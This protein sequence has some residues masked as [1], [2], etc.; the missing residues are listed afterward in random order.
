MSL[1]PGQQT[2]EKM[3][4]GM[5]MGELVFILTNIVIITSWSTRLAETGKSGEARC[6]GY[7]RGGLDVP[8]PGHHHPQVVL[9]H[10][11]TSFQMFWPKSL[12]D[13]SA[14]RSTGSFPTSFLS[15]IEADGVG[16]FH[17]QQK[18]HVKDECSTGIG[19]G[20]GIG[21]GMDLRV[22]NMGEFQRQSEY[23]EWEMN[24]LCRWIKIIIADAR[25]CL[26][27][28]ESLVSELCLSFLTLDSWEKEHFFG[29]FWMLEA[30]EKRLFGQFWTIAIKC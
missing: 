10:R 19:I 17:R 20:I 2:F 11:K 16:E 25:K 24:G 3:I 9:N 8:R 13:K 5:Y 4:S 23:V 7:G 1:N 6:G 29:I 18:W 15:Q 21:I 30:N 14:C 28:L 22:L 12:N 26:P 27:S